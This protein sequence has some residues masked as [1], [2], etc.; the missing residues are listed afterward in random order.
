MQE[1]SCRDYFSTG[2]M[3][4]SE[5]KEECNLLSLSRVWNITC[6]QHRRTSTRGIYLMLK[7]FLISQAKAYEKTSSRSNNR[8]IWTMNYTKITVQ[9]SQQNRPDVSPLLKSS[10]WSCAPFQKMSFSLS[11]LL[12]A[13]QQDVCSLH[14]MQFGIFLLC[15]VFMWFLHRSGM[16]T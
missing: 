15:M 2:K 14:V 8:H 9:I 11:R 7:G 16:H 10:N 13:S 3:P 4:C 1:E 12:M 6:L 5:R